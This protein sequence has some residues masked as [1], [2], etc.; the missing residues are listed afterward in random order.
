MLYKLLSVLGFSDDP[1]DSKGEDHASKR[2]S[3]RRRNDKCV[4]LV[5]G[6]TVPVVD[7]STGGVRIFGDP[8][9]VAIG[10]EMEIVLKFQL[11]QN[12]TSVAHRGKV[13]RKMRDT[14][15]LQFLPLTAEVRQAFRHIID[16]YNAMEFASSQA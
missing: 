9:A 11:N 3:P 12:I 13:V 15:A 1:A 5:D 10:Q 8:R 4:G 14:V 6:K 7:W 2:Q 16:N